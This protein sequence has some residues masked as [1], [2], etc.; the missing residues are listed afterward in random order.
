[1]KKNCKFVGKDSNE[2]QY[3]EWYLDELKTYGVINKYTYHNK[4]RILLQPTHYY[5]YINEYIPHSRKKHILSR[6]YTYTPDYLIEWKEGIK[7]CKLTKELE[8]YSFE[9]YCNHKK[10]NNF[11][12]C[13]NV[14]DRYYS[15]IDVKPIFERFHDRTAL[16]LWKRAFMLSYFNTIVQAVIPE[17]LFKSTFTPKRY[18]RCNKNMKKRSI[19]WDIKTIEEY[20]ND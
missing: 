2:E 16:F 5:T 1:M 9:Y 14:N 10:V 18:L 8:N 6:K 13:S 12:W 3:F 19:K 7:F 15:N 4:K 20:F 11:F 17:V